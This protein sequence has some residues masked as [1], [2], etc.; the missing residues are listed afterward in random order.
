MHLPTLGKPNT[1]HMENTSKKRKENLCR[2][3]ECILL[4]N[5]ETLVERCD[6]IPVRFVTQGI[7]TTASAS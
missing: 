2:Y 4:D 5:H 7:L 3:L 1:I 6:I